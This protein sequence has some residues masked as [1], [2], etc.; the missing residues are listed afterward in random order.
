MVSDAVC[1]LCA[2]GVLYPRGVDVVRRFAAT[3]PLEARSNLVVVAEF[4]SDAPETE[5]AGV[6]PFV[7]TTKGSS[8]TEAVGKHTAPDGTGKLVVARFVVEEVHTHDFMLAVDNL[9]QDLGQFLHVGGALGLQVLHRRGQ[10]HTL[11]ENVEDVALRRLYHASVVGVC[12]ARSIEVAVLVGHSE[13]QAYGRRV[14]VVV[15]EVED[16]GVTAVL[17]LDDVDAVV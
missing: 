12:M 13:V 4:V 2:H 15:G 7:E 17:C 5:I 14:G 3:A 16:V 1:R 11:G 9:V 10:V 8:S 6:H